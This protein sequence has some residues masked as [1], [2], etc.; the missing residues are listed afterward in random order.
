MSLKNLIV[1]NEDN[2]SFSTVRAQASQIIAAYRSNPRASLF[3]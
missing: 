3:G 1:T 2:D